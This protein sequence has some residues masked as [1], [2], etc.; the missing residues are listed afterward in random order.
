MAHFL[1]HGLVPI[2][3]GAV[4]IVLLLGLINMLRGGSGHTSQKLMRLR[5]LL[6]FVAIVIIM[7]TIWAMSK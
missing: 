3:I 5:V 2:A 6:Q 4:A 1:S 7:I